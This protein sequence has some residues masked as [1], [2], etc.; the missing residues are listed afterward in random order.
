MNR[1]LSYPLLVHADADVTGWPTRRRDLALTTLAALT[2]HALLY[3]LANHY[4]FGDVRQLELTALDLAMP[5]WPWTVFLYLSD[6]ALII[7]AFQGCRTRASADRF[8]VTELVV[9]GLATLVHWGFP[10]S[11][12]RELYPLPDGLAAAPAEAMRLLRV[13]DA[14]T[15]CL[16]SLHVAGAVLGPLLIR[17]EQPRA[18]PWLMSWAAVVCLSTL[19]TKQHYLF[20]VMAGIALASL[21]YL[22]ANRVRPIPAG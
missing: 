8:L 16:P 7:V 17:R 21:A 20:D 12:P 19:T 4:P 5:F 14:Q 1:S 18:F 10:V 9:I 22:V 2:F 11:F 6:Y 3:F 13:F 15:S